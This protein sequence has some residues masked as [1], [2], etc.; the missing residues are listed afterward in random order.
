MFL[1]IN[2]SFK[3]FTLPNTILL[4]CKKFNF[5]NFCI[6]IKHL[7]IQDYNL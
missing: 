7:E 6:F 2:T 5:F 3:N 1:V 4:N